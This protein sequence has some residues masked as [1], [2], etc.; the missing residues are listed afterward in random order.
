MNS[1]M[2][3]HLHSP[4]QCVNPV[5]RTDVPKLLKV[6]HHMWAC[7]GWRV[8]EPTWDGYPLIFIRDVAK[9]STLKF[10]PAW[11]VKCPIL[12]YKTLFW[13]SWEWGGESRIHQLMCIYPFW[14]PSLH[15]K[16]WKYPSLKKSGFTKSSDFNA[17][18]P[19]IILMLSLAATAVGFMG[20]SKKNFGELLSHWFCFSFD[21]HSDNQC[22]HTNPSP[23]TSH[24]VARATEC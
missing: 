20:G 13:E 8:Y 21:H 24:A 10:G 14:K 11:F 19:H 22:I 7:R 17:V 23:R 15:Q 4:P 18:F 2:I 16:D 12:P 1:K 3:T 5:R 9:Q 6:R